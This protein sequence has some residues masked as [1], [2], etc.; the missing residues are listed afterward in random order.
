MREREKEKERDREKEE[1]ERREREREMGHIVSSVAG[2]KLDGRFDSTGDAGGHTTC[3]LSWIFLI[4]LIHS[5][6]VLKE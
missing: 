2:D 4:S 3:D 6:K 5:P 1:E